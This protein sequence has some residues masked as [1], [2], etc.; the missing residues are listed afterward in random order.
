MPEHMRRPVA[1]V[2]GGSKG[3]GLALAGEFGRHGHDLI[4][5]AR[6]EAALERAASGLRGGGEP[7]RGFSSRTGP[8]TL[9]TT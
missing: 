7:S 8:V 9:C 3:I 4:L 2:T 6:D 5:V 1:L